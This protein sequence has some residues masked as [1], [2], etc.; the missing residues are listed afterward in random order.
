MIYLDN[1][2]TTKVG[3]EVMEETTA[4]DID[5]V[6]DELKKIVKRLRSMSPEYEDLTRGT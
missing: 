2:A 4:E 5:F 6:V 3:R 1:A